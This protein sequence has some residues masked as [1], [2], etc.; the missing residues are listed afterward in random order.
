MLHALVPE[1]RHSDGW[2]TLRVTMQVV[3]TIMDHL[4]TELTVL[5]GNNDTLSCS[6]LTVFFVQSLLKRINI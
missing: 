4:N 6:K 3:V 1:L 5:A 2:H